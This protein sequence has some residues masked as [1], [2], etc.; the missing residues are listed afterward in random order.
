M[1]FNSG[2][3]GLKFA[4]TAAN[5]RD[6]EHA[7]GQLASVSTVVLETS[8]V[9]RTSQPCVWTSLTVPVLDSS[10]S[11]MWT[12]WR[13]PQIFNY[14]RSLTTS[15]YPAFFTQESE[16][17]VHRIRSDPD[18][19]LAVH[20]SITFLLLPTWYTNFLFIHINYIKLNSS[21]CFEFNP[22][23]IRRSTT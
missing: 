10:A 6:V 18:I 19:W 1:G 14:R 22:L 8:S 23:I 3:K 21:T 16:V 12:R 9:G 17:N 5:V 15:I 7:A 11:Q 2:F 4:K 13:Q 20:H